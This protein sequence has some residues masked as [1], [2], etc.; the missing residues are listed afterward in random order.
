[1][2]GC[3]ACIF[4]LKWGSPGSG[5]GQFSSQDGVAAD[6]FGNV[7]VADGNDRV[8]LFGDSTLVS[9]TNSSTNASMTSIESTST[10]EF[11]GSIL[12]LFTVLT[13][14]LLVLRRISSD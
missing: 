6:G 2:N 14:A 9:V 5:N 1:V 3:N 13:I 12:S 7:Y 8:E 11:S 10:P 4:I